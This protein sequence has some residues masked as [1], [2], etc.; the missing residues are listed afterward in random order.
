MLW[1]RMHAVML[2]LFAV[3]CAP[4]ARA[5]EAAADTAY[6]FSFF[7]GNGETGLYLASSEDGL[8]WT[9]LNNDRP[10]LKPEVGG[11]LMRDPSIVRGPDGVFHMVWTTGW[12]D[13]GIGIAHSK[14]LV[15]WSEQTFL[16]VMEHEPAAKN[17]WAPEIYYDASSE[18]YLIC[19]AT[20]IPGRFPETEHARN[21]NNHR[22]YFVTTKDFRTY[23]DTALFYDPGFNVIDTF[24]VKDAENDRYAM[25]LKN[26]TR[27]PTAEKNI[28]VAFSEKAAGPYGPVS[29]PIHGNYWAEGPSALRVGGRWIVYF[30]RYTEGRY[31]AAASHDLKHWEDIS[32]TVRFPSGTRHG[33]A[34]EVDRTV[35]ERIEVGSVD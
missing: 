16:P 9:A 19:W 12:W 23:T 8:H 35:V 28:R 11:K 33:T 15:H 18:T 32:D 22:M 26:E 1:N 10:L 29:E 20:T 30:D 31:G 2:A 27:H 17:C 25:F 7:R 4:T 13:K 6:L 21:D 24:I 14:D 3:S 5:D 34:L